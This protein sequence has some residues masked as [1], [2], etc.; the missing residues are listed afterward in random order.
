MLVH[1]LLKILEHN[2]SY[3]SLFCLMMMVLCREMR[4]LR[5][6]IHTNLFLTY[7]LANTCWILTALMQE[8]HFL[9]SHVSHAPDWISCK[10]CTR[11]MSANLLKKITVYC[12]GSRFNANH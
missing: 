11:R 9:G 5:N 4:C 8:A 10:S 3:H 6:K 2:Y 7:I 1:A 12:C